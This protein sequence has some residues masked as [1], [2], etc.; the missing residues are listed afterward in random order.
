[1]P[2]VIIL[3]ILTYLF[4]RKRICLLTS[5]SSFLG[6]IIFYYSTSV[7]HIILSEIVQGLLAAAQ[8]TISVMT[9][10][11]Y[12]SPKNRGLFLP[13]KTAS[14]FWGIWVSNAMGTFLYWKTIGLF[15]IMCSIFNIVCV[16]IWPESPYWLSSKGR[17]DECIK[18]HRWLKGSNEEAEKELN[19]LVSR[20]TDAIK[21]RIA[22]KKQITLF[23]EMILL[24]EVYKPLGLC[25]VAVSLYH[26][27][28]KFVYTV[29]SV[30]ILKK[31]TENESAAYTG[32]LILDGVTIVGMYCGSV[33]SKYVKRRPLLFST[34]I[35]AIGFLFSISIYL[36]LTKLAVIEE[37]KYVTVSLLAGFSLSI[38]IGPMILAS[39]LYCEL[40][41]L[42]ARS[43]CLCLLSF[44]AKTL[45]ASSLKISPYLFKTLDFYGT[46][47]IFGIISSIFVLIAFL[48]FPETK[49]KTLLEISDYFKGQSKSVDE[50]KEL[51]TL[52]SS[53]KDKN[54]HNL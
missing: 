19:C 20:N 48:Y 34:S 41:P 15:G 18:S 22:L 47:L 28:G 12:T 8:V 7:T 16:F 21:S 9:V 45:I 51:L 3:S 50:V 53:P 35:L 1:M 54:I 13:I 32:M 30:Q 4:G 2:N 46:F 43:V 14:I 40:V 52:T 25:M 38:S 26:C 10:T 11:E 27:S 49:D 6:F 17:I 36:Y 24:K 23:F 39:T 37:N 33:I 5:F 31:I 42:K 29:Y 44:Y